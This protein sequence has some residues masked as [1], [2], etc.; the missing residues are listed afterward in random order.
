MLSDVPCAAS[1]PELI[2]QHQHHTSDA[3]TWETSFFSLLVLKQVAR[4]HSVTTALIQ[5]VTFTETCNEYNF[6]KCFFFPP[7]ITSSWRTSFLIRCCNKC[8]SAWS[9]QIGAWSALHCN[10]FQRTFVLRMR[11]CVWDMTAK[12]NYSFISMVQCLGGVWNIKAGA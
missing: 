11:S 7:S 2:L 3:L 1:H 5:V 9:K 8:G 4:V 12:L 6:A 10:Y